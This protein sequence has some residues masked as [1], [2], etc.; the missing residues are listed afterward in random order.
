MYYR[1]NGV[2]QRLTGAPTSAYVPQVNRRPGDLRSD[3]LGLIT[4]RPA[5]I[6]SVEVI[7]QSYLR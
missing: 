7:T 4:D 5:A 1:L 3:S 2:T 6:R